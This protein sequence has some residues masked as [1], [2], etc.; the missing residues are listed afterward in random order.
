MYTGLLIVFL[1]NKLLQTTK[2]FFNGL[3][4]QSKRLQRIAL[5]S[6]CSYFF[7]IWNLIMTVERLSRRSK[8]FLP[9]L[10]AVYEQEVI[11]KSISQFFVTIFF[12]NQLLLFFF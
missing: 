4:A 6:L 9:L 1:K 3:K 11:L 12:F 2:Q 5:I 10:F 7:N 8:K